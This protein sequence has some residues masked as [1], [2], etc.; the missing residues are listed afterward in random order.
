MTI[1]VEFKTVWGN[2]MIY[3]VCDNAKLLA[4]LAKQKTFT[5]REIEI[6][7]QLGYKIEAISTKSGEL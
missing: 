5:G 6:I 7:K 1:K 4:K 3:P 2:E